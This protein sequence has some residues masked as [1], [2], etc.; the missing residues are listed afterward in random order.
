GLRAARSDC[1]WWH[2]R[3]VQGPPGKPEPGGGSEDDSKAFNRLDAQLRRSFPQ[4]P[5]C[6]SG[7]SLFACGR[8]LQ[9]ARDSGRGF[10]FVF[11]PGRLPALWQDFQSLLPLCPEQRLER[12][13]AEGV[14]QVYQWVRDLSYTDDQKRTWTFTAI[15]CQE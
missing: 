2:G 15:Q 14:R 3:G 7:Y 8:S 13:T 6:Y 11:K 5:I 4:L 12:V 10:V 9:L 1:S